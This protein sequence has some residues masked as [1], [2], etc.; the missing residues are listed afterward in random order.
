MSEA[1]GVCAY[2]HVKRLRDGL[3]YLSAHLTQQ[4]V[5]YLRSCGL[6]AVDIVKITKAACCDVMIDT[7]FHLSF[8]EFFRTAAE[9]FFLAAVDAYADIRHSH[10]VSVC[11]AVFRIHEFEIA[12]Y[13]LVKQHPCVLSFISQSTAKRRTRAQSVSVRALVREKNY[14]SCRSQ[15]VSHFAQRSIAYHS[16]FPSSS[17]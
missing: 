6:A 5:Y 10:A 2:P 16:K 14:S 1:A 7:E 11:R 12:S 13:L 15:Q 17:L 8:S 4:F 3:F 9:A